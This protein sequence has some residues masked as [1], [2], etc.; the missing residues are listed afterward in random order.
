M[1][2]TE[3][4]APK[5]IATIDFSAEQRKQL[6]AAS[7]LDGLTGLTLVDLDKEARDRMS[8]SLVRATVAV[9]CW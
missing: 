2:K 3:L 8:P 7:G 6:E 5:T 4:G 1:S 9:L